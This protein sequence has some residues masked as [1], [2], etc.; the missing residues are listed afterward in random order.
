LQRASAAILPNL[1]CRSSVGDRAIRH[2]LLQATAITPPK[3]A[4]P[5]LCGHTVS[6]ATAAAWL[7]VTTKVQCGT[8]A[9]R[10]CARAPTIVNS[11]TAAHSTAVP[12]PCTTVRVPLVSAAACFWPQQLR[13]RECS[14]L[15]VCHRNR[16]IWHCSSLRV[17]HSNHAIKHHGDCDVCCSDRASR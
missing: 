15:A 9:A 8:L 10:L 16:T 17:Y 1:E 2:N 7:C 6:S 5:C 14:S 12:C 11:G 4:V 13:H 3:A